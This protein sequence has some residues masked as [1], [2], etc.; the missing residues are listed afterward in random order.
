MKKTI[1]LFC[2]L[3]A[4]INLSAHAIREEADL[5][6]EKSR[7]SYAFGMIFGT[8]FFSSGLEIDYTA[9]S[10]GLRAAMENEPTKFS[11]EEA[12]ELA[13]A[14]FQAAAAKQNEGNRIGELTFLAE[15]AARPEVTVTASGLQYE[16]ISE[17]GGDRPVLSDIVQVHYEGMLTDGSVFDSSYADETPVEFPLNA[18][19]SGWS[20]GL[21]L[22]TVGSTY[23]LYIPSQLAY[24]ERGAN[25][26]IPPYSTLI[27]T[28]ELVDIVRPPADA[29]D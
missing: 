1:I 19:I 6:R 12:I 25:P 23:R 16:V 26:V 20:E 10:D 13:E 24:G 11:R 9:F 21:Q 15:N 4:G 5:S 7:T 8:E 14:A 2:L 29:E 27:F 28:V 3:A 18:V 17:G 22:M